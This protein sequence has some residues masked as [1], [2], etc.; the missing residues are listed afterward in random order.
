[1]VNLT[2]E[3]SLKAGPLLLNTMVKHYFDRIRRDASKK[4]M[5]QLRRDELAYDEAFSVI[6]VRVGHSA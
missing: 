1:M 3:V 6:K 4:S 2:A 5:V